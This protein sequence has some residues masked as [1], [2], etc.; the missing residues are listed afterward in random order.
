MVSKT[1]SDILNTAKAVALAEVGDANTGK[2][3]AG[4]TDL[5]NRE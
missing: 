5:A 1:A 2:D 3:L 4:A